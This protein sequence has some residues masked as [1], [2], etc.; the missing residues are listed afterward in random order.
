MK[1]QLS[2]TAWRCI[3]A[4]LL[5]PLWGL[6]GFGFGSGFDLSAQVTVSNMATTYTAA[7]NKISFT[8]TWTSAPHNNQIWVITDYIKV[9]GTA[10]TGSWSR[11]T[12]TAVT[13]NSGN[14]SAATYTGQRGFWLSATGSSGSANVT[15]T[16]SL[17]AGVDK[18]NWCAYALNTPPQA[19]WQASGYKLQGTPPFVVNGSALSAGIKTFGA[20][21]CITSL[22]DATDNPTSILPAAPSITLSA[23]SSAQTAT[24]NAALPALKYTTARANGATRTSGSFPAGVT[25]SWANNTYTI[26]GTPTA[27]G[28]FTYTVAT[29]N[30]QSCTNASKTG[31]ITV[32]PAI[33]YTGCTTASLN[34]GTVGFTSSATYERNGLIISSPVTAT[35]CSG[36][37]SSF[38]GGSSSATKADCAPSIQA[39]FSGHLFTWCM[40][41]QYAEQLCPSPWR[42]PTMNDHCRIVNN[43]PNICTKVS[44]SALTGIGYIPS[45][46]VNKNLC[47]ETASAGYWSSGERSISDGYML[48]LNANNGDAS[49]DYGNDKVRGFALR[50]VR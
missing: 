49:P 48:H 34:L 7:N 32:N 33:T 43:D 2:L 50:C 14:G 12:V 37:C 22:T 24:Q 38:D 5:F 44:W 28:T 10:T 40:V 21:T 16:L 11:A 9:A 4:T 47:T 36:R 20:G 18:F 25:G 26:S 3:I 13:K 41:V 31:T 19:V 42:V 23:G 39:G 45:G 6:G 35:Y 15:A 8:V 46:V 17:A 1:K 30:S 27:T 29:T